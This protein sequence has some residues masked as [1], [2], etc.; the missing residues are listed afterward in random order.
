MALPRSV[1]LII[2]GSVASYKSL[3]LIRLLRARKVEVTAILSKGGSQWQ[4]R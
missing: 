3:E 4:L 2:T 1:L